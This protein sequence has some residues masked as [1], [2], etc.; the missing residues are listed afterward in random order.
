MGIKREEEYPINNIYYDTDEEDVVIERRGLDPLSI[1]KKLEILKGCKLNTYFGEFDPS[2][3]L[4]YE[5]RDNEHERFKE[6]NQRFREAKIG[7]VLQINF[8]NSS[9]H[10]EQISFPEWVELGRPKTIKVTKEYE[11]AEEL[12]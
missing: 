9:S 3:F 7:R 4:P 11:C 8:G 10:V 1:D 12:K 6:W 2:K 5:G